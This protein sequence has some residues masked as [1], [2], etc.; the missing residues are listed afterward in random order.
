[1]TEEN[2]GF[3]FFKLL[4]ILCILGCFVG[5]GLL[6]T[7]K[8]PAQD[9]GTFLKQK[10]L[11]LGNQIAPSAAPSVVQEKTT[12]STEEVATDRPES[13]EAIPAPEKASNEAESLSGQNDSTSVIEEE[14][15]EIQEE[16]ETLPAIEEDDFLVATEVAEEPQENSENTEEIIPDTSLENEATQTEQIEESEQTSEESPEEESAAIN[17][18][19]SS[20][21]QTDS[22][23][24]FLTSY[25]WQDFQ[26]GKPCQPSEIFDDS[27]KEISNLIYSFCK[28]P[29][30][31]PWQKWLGTFR[32][33]KRTYYVQKTLSEKTKYIKYLKTI[34]YL[35]FDVYQTKTTGNS[36]TD[37]FDQIETLIAKRQ[38]QKAVQLLKDLPDEL[39]R[40]SLNTALMEGN[41][42]LEIQK[43]LNNHSSEGGNND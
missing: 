16:V 28:F 21:S 17:E 36:L 13:E 42:L 4:L 22:K 30:T 19:E 14:Q 23:N 7:Q 43:F 10:A 38:T 18:E 2:K 32:E 6:Y 34:P 37:R 9:W 12:V 33:G 11:D 31:D 3:S 20:N 15:T 41:H 5:A 26:S 25:S 24:K 40:L 8:D 39:A 29:D 1:M 35:L 27:H